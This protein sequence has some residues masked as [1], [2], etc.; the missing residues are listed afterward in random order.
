MLMKSEVEIKQNDWMNALKTL[1]QAFDLPI[2][3]DP[4]GD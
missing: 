3:K 2:V 1:E 4:Y